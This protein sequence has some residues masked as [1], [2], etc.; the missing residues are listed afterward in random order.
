MSAYIL[1]KCTI[2][3]VIYVLK[4]TFKTSIFYSKVPQNEG[5]AVSETQNT[6]GSPY[7][8]FNNV[9][10]FALPKKS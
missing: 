1:K 5:N 3:K 4:I 7:K 8:R 9:T 6:P 2:W 10:Y